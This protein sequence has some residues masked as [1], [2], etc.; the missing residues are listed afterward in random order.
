MDEVTGDEVTGEAVTGEGVTGAPVF[1]IIAV[2]TVS[3]SMFY[4][5]PTGFYSGLP[6]RTPDG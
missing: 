3:V 5:F 2:A 4:E 1:I 6:V